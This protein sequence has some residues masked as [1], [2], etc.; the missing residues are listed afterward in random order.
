M[1]CDSNYIGYLLTTTEIEDYVEITTEEVGDVF[2]EEHT[3]NKNGQD[4]VENSNKL[5]IAR[6]RCIVWKIFLPPNLCQHSI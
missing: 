5:H 4:A 3:E 6:H 2:P 1:R